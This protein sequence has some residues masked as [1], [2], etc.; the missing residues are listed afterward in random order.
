MNH[1]PRAQ[2]FDCGDGVPDLPLLADIDRVR[3]PTATGPTSRPAAPTA[4]TAPPSGATIVIL[5]LTIAG[6]F[7]LLL[8]VLA[9][10]NAL[11]GAAGGLAL[12]VCGLTLVG[13]RRL[14]TILFDR[15]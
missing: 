15:P 9:G 14:R 6:Q 1:A 12:L 4:T 8:A 11:V 5:G 3:P 7:L 10:G 13:A 2:D